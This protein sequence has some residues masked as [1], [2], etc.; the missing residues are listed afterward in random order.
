MNLHINIIMTLVLNHCIKSDLEYINHLKYNNLQNLKIKI[1]VFDIEQIFSYLNNN[2]TDFDIEFPD[3]VVRDCLNIFNFNINEYLC[4]IKNKNKIHIHSKDMSEMYLEMY[5]KVCSSDLMIRSTEYLSNHFISKSLDEFKT[6]L[7]D[8]YNHNLFKNLNIQQLIDSD[9]LIFDTKEMTTIIT[10]YMILL[11]NN[12][13]IIKILNP[14]YFNNHKMTFLISKD[15]MYFNIDMYKAHINIKSKNQIIMF[16]STIKSNIPTNKS[17]NIS[18]TNKSSNI[19]SSN[20]PIN[21]FNIY[22]RIKMLDNNSVEDVSYYKCI[23]TGKK[24]LTK[25]DYLNNSETI[26]HTMIN[27]NSYFQSIYT[28][29][30]KYFQKSIT[31][32]MMSGS[33]GLRY[34]GK[35]T[36]TISKSSDG[37][38]NNSRVIKFNDAIQYN[39]NNNDVKIDLITPNIINSPDDSVIGWKV[40]K[41]FSGDLRIV[42]LFIPAESNKIIPIGDDFLETNFKE[43][44]DC[45]IVM[46]IQLAELDNEKSVIPDEK[47]A[48]SSVY[49]QYFE[50]EIGKEVR[51]DGFSED[52]T[53]SCSKGIHYFRNR[54]AVFKTYIPGYENI[55]L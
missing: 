16:G 48:Y 33:D 13:I 4:L 6:C 29:S 28:N 17:S 55:D 53:I 26:S 27:R 40:C 9:Y 44:T 19:S 46:D 30:D 41:S 51:P 12:N 54:R 5:L 45:A 18:P 11:I 52:Q 25:T 47:I 24:I 20:I 7:P 37:S 23:N 34:R 35:Q 42:K 43:R 15:N 22:Y 2:F 50:Y 32:C 8:Y 14:S 36:D 39:K 3:H 38:I 49:N 10:K 1:N 31:K 21:N